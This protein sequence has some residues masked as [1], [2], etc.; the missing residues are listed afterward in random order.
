[1]KRATPRLPHLPNRSPEALIAAAKRRWKPIKTY[2]LFSGGG[3]SGVL[4]HRCRDHYDELL[5]I[6]TGAAIPTSEEP[7]ITGV[8]DHVRAFAA[9]LGKPLLI[10]RS[11]NCGAFAQAEEERAPMRTF[12]PQWW[13]ERIEALEAEAQARG[14]RGWRWG[15]YDLDGNQAAGSATAPAGLLCSNCRTAGGGERG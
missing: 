13:A 10:R 4:A 8:E 9:Q 14:I 11:G 1:V 12:W 2:C 6:D 7:A 3:D 15:G 5:Y